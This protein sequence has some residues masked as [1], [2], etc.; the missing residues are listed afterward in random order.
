MEATHRTGIPLYCQRSG[1]GPPLIGIAGFGCAHWLLQPLAAHLETRYSVW[2]PD[3]RGIGRSP[4]P[5]GPFDIEDLATDIL[6]IIHDHIKTPVHLLGVSMG[7]FV[8]QKLMTMAPE[9]IKTAAILCSTSGG[10]RFRPLFTY[11]SAEQM[12]RVLA[13]DPDRYARW[14]LEPVVS[15]RL[16]SHPDAFEYMLH[17]RLSHPEDLQQVMEQYHAMAR[18][19]SKAIALETVDIPV[20]VGCG[21]Q[22]PV[23]PVA[24]SRLLAQLLPK[25]ELTLFPETDHLFFVEKPGEVGQSLLD[26]FS[27]HEPRNDHPIR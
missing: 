3:H 19:F 1:I 24:N 23:F 18:F 15:P 4:K 9:H 27:R 6:K 14:I 13:M 2:L 26:F 22:D 16:A 8:V 5:K 11:W 12:R 25:G 20:W 21:E 10:P 7:G 17:Q